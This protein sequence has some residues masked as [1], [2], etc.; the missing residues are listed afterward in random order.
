MMES[1]AEKFDAVN[2]IVAS[3]H[4]YDEYVLVMMPVEKT[5]PGVDQWLRENLS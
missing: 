5:T 4:S 1:V 3:L 2:D